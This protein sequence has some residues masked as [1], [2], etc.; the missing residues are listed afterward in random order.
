MTSI[1]SA[2]CR[3]FCNNF[4][5]YYLKNERLFVDILLHFLNV[6]EIYNILKKTMRVLA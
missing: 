3:N 5:R 1:P 4:K 6:H 2:M